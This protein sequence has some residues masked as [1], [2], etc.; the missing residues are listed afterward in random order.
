MK[1]NGQTDKH[2]PATTQQPFASSKRGWNRF[3]DSLKLEH[4]LEFEEG[5]VGIAGPSKTEAS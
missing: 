5:D 1:E 3:L 4:K 2:Q